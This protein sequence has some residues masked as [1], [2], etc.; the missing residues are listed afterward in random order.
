MNTLLNLQLDFKDIL[1]NTGNN[2][3]HYLHDN[4]PSKSPA[5]ITIY[6]NAYQRRL[7]DTLRADYPMLE[8]L[9]GVE[10]FSELAVDYIAEYPSK[11]YTLRYFGQNLSHF[12]KN[13]LVYQQQ[14]YLAEMADFEWL[15]ADVFDLADTQ[16]A[17]INDMSEVT[18]EDWPHLKV[19]YQASMGWLVLNW[20][21]V[22]VYRAMLTDSE[23]PD[24]HF[25]P[26]PRHCLI[27]RKEYSSFFRIIDTREWLAMQI[28]EHSSFAQLC[29]TLSILDDS[30]ENSA[31]NA[32][33][34]LK[35]WLSADLIE[36][37]N[38]DKRGT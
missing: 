14:P 3:E 27:W 1:Q 5:A 18:P 9:L 6:Q 22:D 8:Q 11:S 21:I 30:D 17:T 32:A 13:D 28:L 29:E 10:Y 16:N 37:I 23:V 19:N 4:N 24:I 2:F 12:L 7:I 34:Y 35:A 26:I 38:I 33:T 15:L 36:S 20:N 25:S 31:L